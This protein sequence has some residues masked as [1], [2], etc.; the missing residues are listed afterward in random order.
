MI[1]I[2]SGGYCE[3]EFE[4][5]FGRVPPAFL[6]IG[7]QR[8]FEHQVRYLRS[9]FA[10]RQIILSV[11][12]D[13]VVSDY[14]LEL[15][16][17]FGVLI[18]RADNAASLSA[19]LLSILSEIQPL[20][21][22]LAILHGDTLL[23]VADHSTDTIYL[24]ETHDSHSWEF[25]DQQRG[26]VWC[27]MFSFSSV[28]LFAEQL[29]KE[30]SFVAAVK[31]YD[32]MRSLKRVYVEEWMDFGHLSTYF[33]GRTKFTTERSFNSLVIKDGVV[34]KRSAD[35]E[36]LKSEAEWYQSIPIK[37][38]RYTP[39]FFG[40]EA[41]K[42]SAAYR[43]EYLPMIPLN[44]IL[45]FGNNPERFWA[46]I[47]KCFDDFFTASE[48]VVADAADIDCA[49]TE[50]T[51]L[52]GD[53]TWQRLEAYFEQSGMDGS[54][55]IKFNGQMMMSP[56]KLAE[57]ALGKINSHN[58]IPGFF[59][60]DLCLSNVLFDSRSQSIKLID[61][62]GLKESSAKSVVGDIRYDIAK[63]AHSILGDYDHIISGRFHYA[64]NGSQYDFNFSIIDSRDDVKAKFLESCLMKNYSV[65]E[66]VSIVV[67]LFLS[68]LPLHLDNMT[69]QKGLFANAYRLYLIFLRD[70]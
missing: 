29:R 7:N 54:H 8:L 31:S 52:I 20:H 21:G 62:R 9:Q 27:G 24:S 56:L 59:H 18:C 60:G 4:S 25:E 12:A 58:S 57:F 49:K 15:I 50:F 39:S 14:D 55:A 17:R 34:E 37:M 68:M 6:P 2:A 3:R 42:N 64:E 38:K 69:R 13:Y 53:K 41:K 40:F 22:E 70:K 51:Y 23:K 63:L 28:S 66:I 45:V 36:K 67:L 16:S 47:F 44:D 10:E 33:V 65:T 48:R 46:Y 35:V 32:A 11:P 5:D 61:P 43:I 30:S 26:L 1:I 19:S